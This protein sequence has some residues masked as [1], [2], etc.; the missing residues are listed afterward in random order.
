[1]GEIAKRCQHRWMRWTTTGLEALLQLRLVKYANQTTIKRSRMVSFIF[2]LGFKCL[3][4]L[5]VCGN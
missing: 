2:V 1:M 5:F 3:D 4:V